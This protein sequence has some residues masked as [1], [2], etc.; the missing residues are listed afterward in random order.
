MVVRVGKFVS[1]CLCLR[2]QKLRVVHSSIVED[3]SYHYQECKAHEVAGK[4][5]DRYSLARCG[6]SPFQAD[7]SPA[8]NHGR[9]TTG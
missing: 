1:S 8:V 3:F 5:V 2:K 9:L 6:R 4:L 7:K